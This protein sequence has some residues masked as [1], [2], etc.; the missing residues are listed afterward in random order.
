ML[1]NMRCWKPYNL[2][3]FV[4]KIF[5]Q[6]EVTDF[7]IPDFCGLTRRGDLLSCSFIILWCDMIQGCLNCEINHIFLLIVKFTILNQIKKKLKRFID[8][9][10]GKL[11]ICLF[12]FSYTVLILKYKIKIDTRK[13]NKTE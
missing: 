3:G 4:V 10:S 8:E 12:F 11:L 6:K 1:V 7:R 9:N 2:H 5:S 13:K